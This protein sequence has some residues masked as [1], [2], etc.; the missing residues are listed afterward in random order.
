MSLVADERIRQ[1]F[2]TWGYSVRDDIDS[3]SSGSMSPDLG[4][5]WHHGLPMSPQWECGLELDSDNDNEDENER[6][7]SHEAGDTMIPSRNCFSYS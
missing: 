3:M 6:D 4:D 7:E 5:T 2:I 1:I